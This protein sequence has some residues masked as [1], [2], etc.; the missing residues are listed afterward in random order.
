[1]C[2]IGG[3]N[4]KYKPDMTKSEQRIPSGS[5]NERRVKERYGCAYLRVD[6][7]SDGSM[8]RWPSRWIWNGQEILSINNTFGDSRLPA[9]ARLFVFAVCLVALWLGISGGLDLLSLS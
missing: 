7:V 6:D 1:M 2:A 4:Y 3:C 8:T 9:H 5:R